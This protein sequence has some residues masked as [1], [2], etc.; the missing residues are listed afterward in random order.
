MMKDQHALLMEQLGKAKNRQEKRKFKALLEL[1][2]VKL[3][4]LEKELSGEAGTNE[5]EEENGAWGLVQVR[6]GKKKSRSQLELQGYDAS[7]LQVF[8]KA[9]NSFVDMDLYEQVIKPDLR[10]ANIPD[11]ATN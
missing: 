7:K 1:E 9:T 11:T 2:N 3:L 8:N 4:R 5:K 10:S 6:R